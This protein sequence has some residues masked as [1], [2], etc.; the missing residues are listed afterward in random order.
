MTRTESVTTPPVLGAGRRFSYNYPSIGP[1]TTGTTPAGDAL[2]A[3]PGGIVSSSYFTV[4]NVGA[5]PN[6]RGAVIYNGR[7]AWSLTSNTGTGT[8]IVPNFGGT[9]RP[10]AMPFQTTQTPGASFQ[11]IDDYWCW[12]ISAVFAFDAIP[13]VITGDIGLAV[14]SG[15]RA[16]IRGASAFEGMEIGPTGVGTVGVIVRQ[17]DAGPVTLAQNV[18]AG[19][20]L[21]AYHR[22]EIRLV[23]P[24]TTTEAAVKFLIDG[25]LQLSVP[26]GAGTVL[27]IQRGSVGSN[28]GMTPGVLNIEA[29]GA[30]TTRMYFA[31]NSL[32]VSAA[33]TEDALP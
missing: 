16:D 14:G 29:A 10:M 22:Y 25:V 15:N 2:T 11:G 1:G 30:A 5:P 32:V 7:V 3:R 8:R 19:L 21:T 33:P 9:N 4:T 12:S 18:A 28:L 23:G 13:G 6:P 24:T 20:D 17:L 27:P 31:P 26:Y